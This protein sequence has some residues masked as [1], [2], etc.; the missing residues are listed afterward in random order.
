MRAFVAFAV[1]AVAATDV[2]VAAPIPSVRPPPGLR[3]F[4]SSI[5]NSVID[6]TT[7]RMADPDLA[8]LFRNC[9]PNTLDT[10]VHAGWT[11]D[12]AFVI[13]GD[14]PAMW[15]RDATNQL[16]PYLPFVTPTPAPPAQIK[17]IC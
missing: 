3:A 1:I 2:A 5:I 8:T 16:L 7:A 15:L 10:T 11:R 9:F 14:I 17:I 13:T 6:A 4:N 12:D